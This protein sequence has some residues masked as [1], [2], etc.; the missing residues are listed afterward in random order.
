[1]KVRIKMAQFFFDRA[2]VVEAVDRGKRQAYSQIGAFVRRRARSSMRRRSGYAPPG[3]PPNAHAGQ[4]KELLYFAYDPGPDS[5][6]I[7]PERFKEGEVPWLLE[8]GGWAMRK[9]RKTGRLR[10]VHYQARPFMG[11]ALEAEKE[12]IPGAFSAVVR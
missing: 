10:R 4:L 6:V 2:A 9:D 12:K 3:S 1:M 8:H 11:P 5:V 7:G